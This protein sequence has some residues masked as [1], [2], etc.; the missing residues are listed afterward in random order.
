MPQFNASESLGA[1]GPDEIA[2]YLLLLDD[3]DGAQRFIGSGV[4]G[5]GLSL[6][7][8]TYSQTGLALGYV[9]PH[10]TVP[11]STSPIVGAGTLESDRSL[12][13]TRIKISLDKF[14]VASYP[15]LGSHEILCEFTGKNQIS[16]ETEELRFA[17]RTFA[18]D[19]QSASI[20][21]HP[22]FLGLTV[23]SDGISFE[24]RTVN[25][26]SNADNA[27]L[28]ALDSSTF[29]S[30]LSLI[31]SAQP[32]LKPFADLAGSVVK[33]ALTRNKNRQVHTFNLGLDFSNNA[34]SARLRLGS[35]V[36]VQTNENTWNWDG[37]VWDSQSQSMKMTDGAETR[38]NYM[39]FGVSAFS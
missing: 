15:G 12:I 24:G 22:I 14:H 13:G 27:I 17:L 6:R 23:G 10:G 31:T 20:S 39:V 34:T 33:A 16:S 18:Q 38:V 32:V 1:L 30:G 25:I 9:Q 35:Y 19:G 37:V 4:S 11:A 2:Q 3:L 5:Q 26:G 28:T 29:K 21:G 7:S 36:V 8:P